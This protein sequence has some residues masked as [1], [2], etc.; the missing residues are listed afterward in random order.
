MK[1]KNSYWSQELVAIQLKHVSVELKL[2]NFRSS[3]CPISALGMLPDWGAV[4]VF[5]TKEANTV[6][7]ASVCHLQ[8]TSQVFHG[9]TDYEKDRVRYPPFYRMNVKS[10]Q[11]L[12]EIRGK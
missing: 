2:A 12:V 7:G 3:E 6:V 11:L 1:W 5:R 8:L 9:T 4:L 10:F